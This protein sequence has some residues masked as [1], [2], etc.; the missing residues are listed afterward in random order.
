MEWR[1]SQSDP[2]STRAL[3]IA[4]PL[5]R[6]IL[7]TKAAE[8]AP[9]QH[10]P[11]DE[12]WKA[13]TKNEIADFSAVGSYFAHYLRDSGVDVPIG[14]LHASWGGSRIEP[15][16]PQAYQG[17]N[18]R[19]DSE[20]RQA[21]QQQRR[22]DVLARYHRE[23]GPMEPPTTEADVN[24]SFVSADATDGGWA[25][26]TL[27][28]MWEGSG[29]P[30][31]DGVFYYRR[32]FD[33][34]AEQAAAP[35]VLHLGPIDDNDVT[36]LNG[37]LVGQTSGYAEPRVY[38]LAG[39]NLKAG[40]NTL[41]VRVTDTGGGGGFHGVADSLY[42]QLGGERVPLSGDYEY[43]IAAFTMNAA[44]RSNAIPTLLYNAMIAPLGDLPLTAVLWYQGES[45]AG[46]ED[47]LAYAAQMEALVGSWRA[48]FA[49]DDLPFYWVQLAN[50]MAP[51][52]SANEPGWAILRDQQTRALRI[53][54][55]GQAVITDIGEAD[56]IHPRNK[57]EVGRRL[58]LH[59]RKAIYGQEVQA[60]SPVVS[61][62]RLDGDDAIITFT[63]AGEGLSIQMKPE[64]RYRVVRSLTVRDRAG[65][66]QWAI[67]VLEPGANSLRV[68]NPLGTGIKAVRYA[69][70]N[71]PDDANLFSEE[72]LPVTPFEIAVE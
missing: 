34:T 29:Y 22:E 56:D 42:L 39:G 67:G 30:D 26:T 6:Q 27:P 64:D 37:K 71:N 60:S 10:L 70:F 55:S 5:I 40:Q 28:G 9:Q 32:T 47:A 49:N 19:D 4:D 51:P 12:S 63:E 59:A 45:N 21:A 17:E 65:D 35:G 48:Q 23:F 53:P 24:P 61:S 68:L 58:S 3:A 50:F 2:D 14:L 1:L 11:L 62:A 31:V 16:I 54:H 69:W 33:L 20:A 44:S 72:G 8:E 25:A 66:W 15:W 36:Y 43:R 52:Q 18:F 7:V 57:W 41:V 38:A 46:E 13:G